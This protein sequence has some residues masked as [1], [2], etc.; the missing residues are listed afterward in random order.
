MMN[1]RT[2]IQSA[3]AATTTAVAMVNVSPVGVFP[4][5][6]KL[7]ANYEM[8][9]DE[10]YTYITNREPH[11]GNAIMVGIDSG[12]GNYI[13]FMKLRPGDAAMLHSREFAV[14]VLKG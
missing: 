9:K 12:F 5:K 4:Q 6:K 14:R 13:D 1:R 3:I 11:D 7:T 10:D 2:F 8:K